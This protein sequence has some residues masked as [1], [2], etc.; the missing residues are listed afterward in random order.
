MLLSLQYGLTA[1]MKASWNGH[2]ECVEVLLDKAAE[3]NMAD[4]VSAV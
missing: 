4:K 1:P 2:M 3:V